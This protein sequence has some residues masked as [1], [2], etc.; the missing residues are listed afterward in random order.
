MTHAKKRGLPMSDR[1]AV[2]LERLWRE[3][4]GYFGDDAERIEHTRRVTDYAREIFSVEQADRTVVE[5][6]AM[7]HDI[8]IPEAERKHGSAA[9]PYQEIEGPPIVRE[10][11]ERLGADADFTETVA[12]MV[13]SHHS[14]GEI[15]TPEFD[16]LWD[17]DWLVNL[18]AEH[19]DQTPEKRRAMIHRIFHTATG[20]AIALAR[21]IP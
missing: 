19:G 9:G 7:L 10:I 11:L 1:P 3:V 12:R 2:E 17:A 6:S 18:P 15:E 5:A 8:G 14:P 21:L 20:R 16:I 4:T 13:G